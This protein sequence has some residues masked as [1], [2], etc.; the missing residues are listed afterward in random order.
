MRSIL[1]D[2][3]S[4]YIL[5][6]PFPIFFWPWDLLPFHV[7][8]LFWPEPW[9]SVDSC[10]RSFIVSIQCSITSSAGKKNW[11]GD[12]REL[13]WK[14]NKL[15]W[16]IKRE[17]GWKQNRD[18]SEA[19]LDEKPRQMGIWPV[20]AI[21]TIWGEVPTISVQNATQIVRVLEIGQGFVRC[22]CCP[23]LF[24]C[25]RCHFKAGPSPFCLLQTSVQLGS[26]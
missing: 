20:E 5:K 10:C 15:A 7:S 25:P 1:S 18:R 13:G 22:T 11:G 4:N 26:A 6:P 16:Q 21:R 12:K 9:Q 3:Y 14:Q 24:I 8:I 17:L 19:S 2:I 23:K